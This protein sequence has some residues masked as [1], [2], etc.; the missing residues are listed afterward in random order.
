MTNHIIRLD[1]QDVIARLADVQRAVAVAE[2]PSDT[3]VAEGV[4]IDRAAATLRLVLTLYDEG[5]YDDDLAR[6][7]ITAAYELVRASE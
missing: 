5:V 1:L 4:A 7:W 2:R 3:G 6:S